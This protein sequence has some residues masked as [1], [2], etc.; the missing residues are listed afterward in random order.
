MT[1]IREGI[2]AGVIAGGAAG[3][4]LIP[5]IASVLAWAGLALLL[6]RYRGSLGCLLAALR[7]EGGGPAYGRLLTRVQGDR[8]LAER[9]IAY[10]GRRG[11]P[12]SREDLAERALERLERDGR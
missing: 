4:V 1:Y 3:L 8:A 2:A 7:G 11:P 5:S 9:L 6:I 12:D 10:E